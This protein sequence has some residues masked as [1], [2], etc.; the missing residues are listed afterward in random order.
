MEVINEFLF[1]RIVITR[2]TGLI[3]VVIFILGVIVYEGALYMWSK[4][5]RE[6]FKDAERILRPEDVLP[7]NATNGDLINSIFDVD[8]DCTDVHG[9]NGTMTFTVTQDWWNSPYKGEKKQ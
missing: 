2:E 5:Y 3:L 8:R 9:E 7:S 1:K 4:A 6:G